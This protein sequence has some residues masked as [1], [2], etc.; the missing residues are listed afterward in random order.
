MEHTEQQSN[1]QHYISAQ[2]KRAAKCNRSLFMH[3]SWAGVPTFFLIAFGLVLFCVPQGREIIRALTDEMVFERSLRYLIWLLSATTLWTALIYHWTRVRFEYRHENDLN[4][5]LSRCDLFISE[6]LMRLLPALPFG[7]LFFSFLINGL[8]SHLAW[9]FY[10]SMTLMLAGLVFTIASKDLEWLSKPLRAKLVIA[11]FAVFAFALPLWAILFPYV[12]LITD[13]YEPAKV[14]PLTQL[15]S[16]LPFVGLPFLIVFRN[17]SRMDANL[18][19]W[20]KQAAGTFEGDQQEFTGCLGQLQRL[21]HVSTPSM[22]WI[23]VQ[24]VIVILAACIFG[25]API[26]AGQFVGPGAVAVF[27]FAAML[28]MFSIISIVSHSMGFPVFVTVGAW[29]VISGYSQSLI[30]SSFTCE[31]RSKSCYQ[32]QV[33]SDQRLEKGADPSTKRALRLDLFPTAETQPNGDEKTTLLNER[34]DYFS[35]WLKRQQLNEPETVPMVFVSVAGGGQRA[36]LWG[37]EVLGTLQDTNPQFD[38]SVFSISAV[39]GGALGTA[40]FT[41]LLVEGDLPAAGGV[42]LGYADRGREILLED[43]LS[44]S[45]SALLFVDLLSYFSPIQLFEDRASALERSWEAAWRQRP[46]V[47]DGEVKRGCSPQGSPS[48]VYVSDA[49]QIEECS[50]HRLLKSDFLCTWLHDGVNEI[51]A[52]FYNSTHRQTGRRIITS[53]VLFDPVI[54]NA[55]DFYRHHDGRIAHSTAVHSSAR[56]PIIS[57]AGVLSKGG[58]LKGYVLDGGYVDNSGSLTTKDI[59]AG[60]I[61]AFVEQETKRRSTAED[62]APIKLRPIFVEITNDANAVCRGRSCSAQAAT[63]QCRGN[64]FNGKLSGEKQRLRIP[65]LGELVTPLYGVLAVR[66]RV[67]ADAAD[68]L[69]RFRREKTCEPDMKD[70]IESSHYI[71]FTLCDVQLNDTPVGWMHTRVRS[72]VYPASLGKGEIN[73]GESISP[74]SKNTECVAYNEASLRALTALVSQE[75]Q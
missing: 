28:P 69:D 61:E 14:S 7:I 54:P 43:S 21:L 74:I 59:A 31:E 33:R 66:G 38:D 51:P 23:F 71:Q 39:S 2:L 5:A 49:P 22:K 6:S 12:A 18:Q 17:S 11:T 72:N 19:K 15:V 30:R 62:S 57:P 60:G 24:F 70:F 35:D 9:M 68:E 50:V 13:L 10:S 67:G 55:I 25:G 37:N 32:H 63:D 41:S 16:L 52:V 65:I 8:G 1:K 29:L 26:V 42:E 3:L 34:E 58:K 56:F 27:A 75:R 44:P 48:F 46:C 36:A 45:L 4:G 64:L 20:Q 40:V 73:S 53:N 47:E